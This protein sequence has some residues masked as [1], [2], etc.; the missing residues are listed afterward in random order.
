MPVV[1]NP[2]AYF[3]LLGLSLTQGDPTQLVW[4]I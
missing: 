2:G 3:N 4:G 1:F